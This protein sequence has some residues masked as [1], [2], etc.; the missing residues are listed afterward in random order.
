MYTGAEIA[1]AAL[2]FHG[3]GYIT[4]KSIV[5]SHVVKNKM[6]NRFT[7]AQILDYFETAG[8]FPDGSMGINFD[9]FKKSYFP[10]LYVGSEDNDDAEDIKAA[11]LRKNLDTRLGE[12]PQAIE[13]R[14]DAIEL[15]LK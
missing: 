14:L 13:D 7:L 8:L 3:T 4:L 5:E 1:Y 10:H 15:K 2:D 12:Q 11:N 6:M 9:T